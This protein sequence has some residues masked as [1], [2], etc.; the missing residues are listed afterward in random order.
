MRG[1]NAL[2]QCEI[3]GTGPF[4][5][6]WFKDKKQIRSSKKYR[7]LS[8][9]SLVSLE[10]FSFNSADVG[11]YECV[12]ANEVGKCGCR[13]THFLKGQFLNKMVPH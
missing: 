6:S 7:L 5:I 10:I 2:L 4:E 1:T 13:A 8:Q 3:S 11:E 9:K 12:V